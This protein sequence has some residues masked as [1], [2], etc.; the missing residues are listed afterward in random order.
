MSLATG[1]NGPYCRVRQLDPMTHAALPFR[2][3]RSRSPVLGL[4]EPQRLTCLIEIA[5]RNIKRIIH[6]V[7]EVTDGPRIHLKTLSL[8]A[9]HRP[10]SF[11]GDAAFHLVPAA[12]LGPFE[13]VRGPSHSEYSGK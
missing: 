7:V 5:H 2:D 13:V 1:F 6:S 8:K 12:A 10:S 11:P 3:Y 9:S 4:L